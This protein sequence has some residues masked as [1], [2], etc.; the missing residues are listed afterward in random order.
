MRLKHALLFI[1]LFCTDGVKAQ[2]TKID[3]LWEIYL[4]AIDSSDFEKAIEPINAIIQL[5]RLES[6]DV[7]RDTLLAIFLNES[8]IVYINLGQYQDALNPA[9]EALAIRKKLFGPDHTDVAQSASNLAWLF[10]NIG[11]YEDA[12][13]LY[14][15]AL[16]IRKKALGLAHLDVATSL[17]NLAWLY[18][19]MGQYEK[20]VP[21]YQ[22]ALAI[23]KKAL[24]LAHPDVATSLNN[25]A[26]LYS[27]M[28]QYEDALP[29]NQEALAI[30]KKAL[31]L[32]H[33]D[34]ATSL[35]NLAL[36]YS[37]M[38]Q[39]EDAL[40][41]NQEALAIRKKALGPHHPDLA[42][43][44]TDL[45]VLYYYM[46][47]FEKALPLN[48]EA[49]VIRKK[50]FGVVHSSVATSLD[51]LALLY[52]KI[53]Q[54]EKAL[55][56][57]I[58]ALAIRKS[59]LRPDHP[60]VAISLNNLALL[61]SD[62]GQ[63]EKALLL[64]QE[65]LAIRK[66]EMG[67]D[68]LAIANSLITLAH[69]YS[70]MGQ[71][72][73]AIPLNQ[74]VLAIRIKAL[75]SGH[76]FVATSLNNLADLYREMGH[77]E[78]S[79][80]LNLE[81]LA[82]WK[83]AL[84]LDHP[85]VAISLNNLAQLY[86][87]M[88]QYEKALSLNHEVLAI[89]KKALGLD[90]PNV[91]T[92]LNN[93]ADLYREMGQYEKALVLNQ[94][95]LAINKKALGS[96][97]P[98]VARSLNNLACLYSNMGQSQKA[99][100]L[101]QESLAIRKKALD[102]D[103]PDL[104]TSLNNIA[105]LYSDMG[106]YEKA[107]PLNLEALSIKK[108]ALGPDH[109][110]VATSLNNLAE[111][112][113]DMGQYEKAFPLYQ[114]TLDITKKQ[115]SSDFNALSETQK[116][117][118]LET[119]SSLFQI[120]ESFSSDHPNMVKNKTADNL[121]NLY[122]LNGLVLRSAMQLRESILS[123]SD[124]ILKND[125][126]QLVSLKNYYSKAL[127]KTVDERTKLG[128]D[129]TQMEDNINQVER[130]LALR[131]K[132][133][134]VDLKKQHINFSQVSS[135]LE[136]NQ[137]YVF[138]YSYPY[139]NG[140]SWTD[141]VL[142]TAYIV[143]KDKQQPERIFL[144]EQHAID[145]LLQ[146]QHTK[147]GVNSM[148]V[149]ESLYNLIIKPLLPYLKN[150]NQLFFTPSGALHSI[151]FSALQ[152]S[153]GS[154]LSDKYSLHQISGPAQLVIPANPVLFTEKSPSNKDIALFGGIDYL[155]DS[156]AMKM[157]VTSFITDTT[158]MFATRSML[159]QETD[160]GSVWQPLPGTMQEVESIEKLFVSNTRSFV[161]YTG[162][163][164]LEEQVKSQQEKQ[165]PKILHIA[166]HGFFIPAPKEDLN[167][168]DIQLRMSGDNAFQRADNP[169]LRSGLLFAG[170]AHTWKG[171]PSLLGAE[172]GILTAMEVSQLNL[173]NTRLSVLSACE[174]GLGDV[175][176]SE[177]VFGLQRAFKLAGVDYILM[178]LWSIPDKETNEYMQYFYT[179]LLN[180]NNINTA[181]QTA[182]NKMRSRYPD[183]PQKWAGMV[184]V[185]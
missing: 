15:E 131:S 120:S 156:A 109:P 146:N 14:Q 16:A 177:G 118:Y 181:Y 115:I 73:K 97:H 107:L 161:K 40:P 11:Q 39:Y 61:Y 77:Y 28:G 172:D 111:L 166:T 93:L 56:L 62:M 8:G 182:Q 99:L 53:G 83:K 110:N 174:T 67:P 71:Y 74:E 17:S 33:P 50:A 145:S 144:F 160:R 128:M 169:L 180:T 125:Y 60:D 147:G 49:L 34:V 86:S 133:F 68:Q 91:A 54:Y 155:A 37:K 31:G 105:V 149:D 4:V 92:S 113:S 9:K 10:S 47:Q 130:D 20:G 164:A 87:S 168:L 26:L 142:Y 78:K 138:Y 81:A 3:S 41:L 132:E 114:E 129:L 154:A 38:G 148:Y 153:A 18:S 162:A 171:E 122:F 82:I 57:H 36:L 66:K 2:E 85:N 55:P 84:G 106:Q 184:L 22:E 176:G 139:H 7:E 173:R 19:K 103:H 126:E 65:G 25:L 96:D 179:E 141:S 5:Q 108:K 104:A 1:F 101:F 12:L 135:T 185:E 100:P 98:D 116:L 32:A 13:P 151:A 88:G 45:A 175:K 80:H 137:A 170:S 58:E 159:P 70:K 117:E 150:V 90:H 21:L 69:L 119:K 143:T 95:S 29:L 64:N 157:A 94:E 27:K 124:T 52:S 165:A 35:N 6:S 158:F 163:M 140:K 79:L 134:A 23:R 48:Q 152:D 102:T 75:G 89:S 44:L 43:S 178:S 136:K 51:N 167:K 63:Y 121:N 59:V 127:T 112:Y 24:G 42:I 183:E 76:P 72:E 46:G 123:S 30:R